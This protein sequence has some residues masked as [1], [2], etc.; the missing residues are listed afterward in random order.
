MKRAIMI[1][2][3]SFCAGFTLLSAQTQI[4]YGSN[5][6]IGK[7]EQVNDIKMYYEVYGEG[8]PL[9]LIHGNS[10]SISSWSNQIPSLS[11]KY[12]VFIADSRA[13]G[14]SYDSDKE[15]TYSLMA[16]DYNALLNKL[17]LDSIY[18]MGWSDGGIIALDLAMNYPSK[19]KKMVLAGTNFNTDSTALYPEVLMTFQNLKTIPFEKLPD[20]LKRAYTALSPQ[21][22]RAP[23]VFKKLMN[24]MIKYPDYSTT[25]ISKIN[26]PALILAGDHDLI[27]EEHTLKLFQCIPHSQLF[28]LP[29]T[30][31]LFLFEKPELVNQTVDAFFSTPYQDLD[32]LYFLK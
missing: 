27:R 25:E 4:Q 6:E 28:I 22:D 15:I 31:H 17:N 3:F 16:S 12:K 29:G 13:Q 7:Y 11:K 9:L 10:G 26:V 21:P 2:V 19:V 14:R 23:I 5:K 20:L 32:R 8:H 1:I 30:S 18:I 24:L